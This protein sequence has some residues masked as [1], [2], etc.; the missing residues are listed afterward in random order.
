MPIQITVWLPIQVTVWAL[1]L[2]SASSLA[3][4]A[5]GLRLAVLSAGPS[6]TL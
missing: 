3:D 5:A 2:L 4:P 1:L 6:V